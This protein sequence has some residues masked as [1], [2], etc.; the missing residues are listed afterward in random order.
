MLEADWDPARTAFLA[1]PLDVELPGG[2]L[3]GE[4]RIVENGDDRLVVATTADRPALLVLAE[5]WYPGWVA[6]VDGVETPLVRV[7]HTFQGVVVDA[8]EHTVEA[9]FRPRSL[10]RG[11]TIYLICMAL[12]VGYGSWISWR[13]LRPAPSAVRS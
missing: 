10:Y 1:E 7:N 12:L 13:S 5:N 3:D 4:A 11:L 9:V 6:T 8:G 2:A